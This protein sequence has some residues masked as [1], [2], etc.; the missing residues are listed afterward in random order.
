VNRTEVPADQPARGLLRAL[1]AAVLGL[2]AVL[3]WRVRRGSTLHSQK[4]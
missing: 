3:V 2:L 1:G 4:T